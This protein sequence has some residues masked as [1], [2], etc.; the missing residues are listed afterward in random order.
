MNAPDPVKAR[1]DHVTTAND[2]D[3]VAHAIDIIILPRTGAS[4]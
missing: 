2:A 3:G 1:A 4:E